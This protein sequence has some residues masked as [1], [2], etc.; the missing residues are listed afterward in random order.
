MGKWENGGIGVKW[1]NRLRYSCV[2][3]P[4]LSFRAAAIIG[5]CV[6]GLNVLKAPRLAGVDASV[7]WAASQLESG[8]RYKDIIGGASRAQLEQLV[9]FAMRHN[10][11]ARLAAGGPAVLATGWRFDVASRVFTD[12]AGA[13]STGKA[14]KAAKAAANKAERQARVDA[15]GPAVLAKGWRWFREFGILQTPP[16]PSARARRPRQHQRRPRRGRRGLREARAPLRCPRTSPF[17]CPA[18][19]ILPAIALCRS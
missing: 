2:A 16:A 4:H 1:V 18:A 13:V 7:A 8:S 14:A 5:V 12:A 6:R 17:C 11:L 15:G 19:A 3:H 10:M 9:S